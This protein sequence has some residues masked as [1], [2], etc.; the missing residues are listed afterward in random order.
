M[1]E[2]EYIV[3][4]ELI[5]IRLAIYILSPLLAVHQGEK[6]QVMT[7]LGYWEEKLETEAAHLRD[8]A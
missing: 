5:A 7:R 6:R 8:S 2:R 3:A 1:T 4:S